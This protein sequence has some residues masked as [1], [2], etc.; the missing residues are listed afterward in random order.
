MDSFSKAHLGALMI[1]WQLCLGSI[2]V[3]YWVQILKEGG[4]SRGSAPK[5]TFRYSTVLYKARH[6]HT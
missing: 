6:P 1:E 5:P 4:E 3:P 2:C